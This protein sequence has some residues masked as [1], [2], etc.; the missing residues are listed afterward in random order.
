MM[1]ISFGH[2]IVLGVIVLLFGGKRLPELGAAAGLGIR[3]FKKGLA[4]E[5][6]DDTKPAPLPLDRKE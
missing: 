6:L 2:M 1:G 5:P 3:S 4:G